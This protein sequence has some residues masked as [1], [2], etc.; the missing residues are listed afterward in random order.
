MSF[1]DYLKQGDEEEQNDNQPFG[2]PTNQLDIAAPDKNVNDDDSLACE[3]L[4]NRMDQIEEQ[5]NRG[6][7]NEKQAGELRAAHRIY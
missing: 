5:E 4:A 3:K 2:M 6:G 7:L 1:V